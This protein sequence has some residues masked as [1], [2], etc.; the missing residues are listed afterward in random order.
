MLAKY[1]RIYPKIIAPTKYL[2]G[3]PSSQYKPK[4]MIVVTVDN[5]MIGERSPFSWETIQIKIIAPDKEINNVSR[6]S[7]KVENFIYKHVPCF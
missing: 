4:N 3:I 6:K 2:L 5:W 7:K 1:S